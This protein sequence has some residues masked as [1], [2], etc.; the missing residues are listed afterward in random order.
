MH[1]HDPFLHEDHDQASL[2]LRATLEQVRTGLRTGLL[3]IE[4]VL[5][6][7]AGG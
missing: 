5:L 2:Q 6:P 3:V 7:Q 1:V 4:A